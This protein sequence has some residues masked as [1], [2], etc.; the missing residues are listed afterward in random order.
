LIALTSDETFQPPRWMR[1]PHLQSML[2][3]LPGRRTWIERRAMALIR[4]S[5]ELLLDCGDDVRLQAFVASQVRAGREQGRRVAV[6]LHGWEGS[7]ESLYVLSLGQELF[8]RGYEVVRLNLRDHGATHH[9]NREIFH[10]CRLSEVI[11]AMRVLQKRYAGKPLHLAGFSL[12]GN[13]MLRVAAQAPAAK[14]DIAAVA[15]VS[16]VLDPAR[17]LVALETGFFAYNNYFVRKWLRSLLKKQEAWPGEYDF[18]EVSRLT[19]LRRMTAMLVAQFTDFPS[20]DAY[21]AGYAITGERLETI[22]APATVVTAADDPI[23]PV[24]DIERIARP[25]HLSLIITRH[26]GHNGFIDHLS[27]STF[28][29]RAVVS[30]FEQG[31]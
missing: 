22:E 12:G 3:S 15:A 7:A 9:L 19:D 26:G 1:G 20:L 10:S 27:N 28:A 29:D 2:P 17:T 8:D 18:A 14:L 31:G 23:I 5:E 21:L 13:F 6:L 4:A 25:K 11:G 16:P 30:A 24:H